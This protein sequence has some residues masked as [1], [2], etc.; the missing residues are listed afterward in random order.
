M[1]TWKVLLAC[2][3]LLQALTDTTLLRGF[4]QYSRVSYIVILIIVNGNRQHIAQP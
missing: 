3:K 4:I 1:V 2:V